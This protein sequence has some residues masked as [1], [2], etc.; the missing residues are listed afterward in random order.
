MQG[1]HHLGQEQL[2][3]KDLL[4]LKLLIS[5]TLDPAVTSH[6]QTFLFSHFLRET[7]DVVGQE[8]VAGLGATITEVDLPPKSAETVEQLLSAWIAPIFG[9][10]CGVIYL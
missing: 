5:D 9:V 8:K 7:F 3:I 1:S 6:D 2:G 10:A 4:V